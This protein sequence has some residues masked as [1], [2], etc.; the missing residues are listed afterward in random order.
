VILPTPQELSRVFIENSVEEVAIAC[1]AHGIEA[2]IGRLRA[3]RFATR[4][5][6]GIE[7]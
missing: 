6:E 5:I 1:P 7:R 4:I 2:L 3:A